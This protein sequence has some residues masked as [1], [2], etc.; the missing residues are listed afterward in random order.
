MNMQYL[1]THEKARHKK[2]SGKINEQISEV[3]WKCKIMDGMRWKR[4]STED[5][6]KQKGSNLS[7]EKWKKKVI[8][9]LLCNSQLRSGN[10]LQITAN[11]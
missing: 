10:Y 2:A 9:K 1:R 11:Q 7:M 6:V 8:C 3:M 5:K 4:S